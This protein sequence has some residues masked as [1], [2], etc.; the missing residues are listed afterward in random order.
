[1][2]EEAVKRVRSWKGAADVAGR[3]PMAAPPV[4]ET[5]RER[6]DKAVT[7]VDG[8]KPSIPVKRVLSLENLQKMILGRPTPSVDSET[9]KD[10]H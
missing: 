10:S 3:P 9:T 7:A 6:G 2:A 1:M 8:P 5:S 4:S